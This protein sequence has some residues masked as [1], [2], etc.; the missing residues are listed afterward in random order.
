MKIEGTVQEIKELFTTNI[1][2]KKEEK[3]FLDKLIEENK[4]EKEFKE[5]VMK[6]INENASVAGTTDAKLSKKQLQQAYKYVN[7]KMGGSY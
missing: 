6:V 3:T 2:F 1:T 4:K 5:K 7:K